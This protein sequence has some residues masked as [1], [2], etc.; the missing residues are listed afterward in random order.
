MRVR[1]FVQDLQVDIK[2]NAGNSKG[3]VIVSAYRVAHFCDYL[4]KQSAVLRLL[5]LPIMVIYKI[6]TDYIMGIY[7]PAETRIGRGLVV[8]HG[9]GLVVHPS[10]IIG[11]YCT[12]RHGV[13]IGSKDGS[14]FDVPNIG[15]GVSIGAM[16][17]IIGNITIGDMVTVGAC[18]LVHRSVPAGSTVFG[19]PAILRDRA[20]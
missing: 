7:I 10:S 16:T 6:I 19:N 17:V 8:Y 2:A 13:T 4:S 11:D 3:L 9:Y 1:K 5:L 12:L 15:S 18:S 14:E 20:N